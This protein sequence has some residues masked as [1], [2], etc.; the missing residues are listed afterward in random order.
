MLRTENIKVNLSINLQKNLQEDEVICPNCKGTGI[1]VND[2]KF[3]LGKFDIGNPFPYKHQ[4]IGGCNHCYNGIQKVCK[5]CGELLGRQIAHDCEG[6]RKEKNKKYNQQDLDKWNKAEKISLKEACNKLE[7]VYV[8]N[9]EHFCEIDS[10]EEYIKDE[11]KLEDYSSIRVYGTYKTDIN[12]SA[13]NIIQNAID[14]LHED[15]GDN[16]SH[17]EELE[18]QEMLDKWVE[19]ISGTETYWPDWEYGI[20]IM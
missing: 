5:H 10:L 9:T 7:W 6:A 3:G 18:L 2:N 11:F 1:Q 12:L 16:I 4:V 8:D 19:G 13:S 20:L 14:D 15:A 17:K